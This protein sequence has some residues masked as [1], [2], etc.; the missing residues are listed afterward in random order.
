M[1]G[2]QLPILILG[3]GYTGRVVYKHASA[4]GQAVIATSRSP[5][6]RLASIP[7]AQRMEFVL[8]DRAHGQGCRNRPM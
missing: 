6:R 5:E 4:Q 8:A 2:G 3:A 7:A 1:E